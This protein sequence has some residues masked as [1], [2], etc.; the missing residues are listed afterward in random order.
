M[1]SLVPALLPPHRP[2][3][4]VGRRLGVLFSYDER[5]CAAAAALGIAVE[6]PA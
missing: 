1:T 5:L 4:S 2:R 6:R 3:P